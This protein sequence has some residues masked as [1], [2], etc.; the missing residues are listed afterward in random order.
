VVIFIA[1]SQ[2]AVVSAGANSLADC[3]ER[4]GKKDART[5]EKPV[6]CYLKLPFF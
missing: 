6:K 3:K 1:A 2:N 5:P 4:S